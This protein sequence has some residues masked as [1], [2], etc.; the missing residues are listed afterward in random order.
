[1]VEEVASH[2]RLHPDTHN[3]TLVLN[4][5]VE[6]HSHEIEQQQ[7]QA[8]KYYKAVLLIG[9]QVV[10]HRAYDYRV[11]DAYQR[12]EQRGS[13]IERKDTFMRFIIT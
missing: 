6:Q 3:V 2:L 5:E 7:G 9:Y 13:H 1:M 4:E 8:C 10:E 12:H 11:D